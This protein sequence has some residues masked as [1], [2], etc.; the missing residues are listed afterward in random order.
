MHISVQEGEEHVLLYS[1]FNNAMGVVLAPTTVWDY[2][3][4]GQGKLVSEDQETFFAL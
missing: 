2:V 4:T 3:E 1:L